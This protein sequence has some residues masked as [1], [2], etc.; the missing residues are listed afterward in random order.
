MA[1]RRSTRISAKLESPSEASNSVAEKNASKSTNRSKA[2]STAKGRPKRKNGDE[3][4]SGDQNKDT[5]GPSTP[6]RKRRPKA[7][8]PATPIPAVV[9]PIPNTNGTVPPTLKNRLAD[10]NSSNALLISP[11]TSRLVLNKPV[12]QVSPSKLSKVTT[13]TTNILEEGLAHLIKVEP[14]L[15]PCIE[16]HHCQIFSPEGLAQE[17]DPFRSLVSSIIS[18][19]VSGAAAKSIKAKFVALFNEDKPDAADHVFPIPSQVAGKSIE[20]LRTAGLSQR[21]AEYIQGLAE[22]FVSGELTASMLLSATYEEVLEAL[23]KVRGLGQWSV[24]MFAFFE[25]KRMDV[26]STGDLG[27]QRGV[28]AFVGKDVGKL[29]AKGGGKWKYMGEKEMLEI[30]EKFRPYRGLFMWY[31]WR[32][33][34]TDV[35]A[36][37][38]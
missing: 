22:K 12:E 26:F 16:Q 35:A 34:N 4:K 15:K 13:T 28:A 19:Q 10:P 17:V 38:N 29:K 30:A 31:M 3:E 20:V 37:M 27:V 14:R 36:L 18:Q 23:I 11:E 33:E 24:E 1:T 5:D 25:L 9:E 7:D 32:W 21:K 6:K 8:E 2:T